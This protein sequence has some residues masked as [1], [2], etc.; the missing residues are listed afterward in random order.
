MIDGRM[1]QKHDID[2]AIG[3][4][5]AAPQSAALTL[6]LSPDLAAALDRFIER[7][8]P[9]MARSEAIVTAFRE[10]AT[11]RGLVATTDDGLRSEELNASNDG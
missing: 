3:N 8:H 5:P 10:W 1:R 7:E 6:N 4:S 9:E 2:Q 11:S